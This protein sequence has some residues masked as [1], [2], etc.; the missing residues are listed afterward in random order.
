MEQL[1]LISVNFNLRDAKAK[2]ETPLYVVIYF[3]TESGQKNNSK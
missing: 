2:R 1:T 3:I